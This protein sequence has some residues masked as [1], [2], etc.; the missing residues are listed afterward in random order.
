MLALFGQISCPEV[1]LNFMRPLCAFFLAL[2]TGVTAI[3]KVNWRW[4]GNNIAFFTGSVVA[5]PTKVSTCT[6]PVRG[7][8][9][10]AHS[11]S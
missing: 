3:E 8:L 10:I 11:F 1:V 7:I 9:L 5:T 2:Q 4:T 6:F